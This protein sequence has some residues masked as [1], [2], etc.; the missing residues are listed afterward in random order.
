MKT[1]KGK[2]VVAS[3]SHRSTIRPVLETRAE[4]LLILTAGQD[5]PFPHSQTSDPKISNPNANQ[6]QGRMANRSGHFADLPVFA[7]DQFERDP[8]FGDA[9]SK[10]N[11]WL[12]R[13]NHCRTHRQIWT[14]MV[15]G[16]DGLRLQHPRLARQRSAALDQN[17]T[18]QVLH[19][20]RRWNSLDLRPIFPLVGANGMEKFLIQVRLITQKE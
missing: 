9:L 11:G 1:E 19:F 14:A 20:L 6:T 7:F 17:A 12:A 13:R 5:F 2:R 15:I 8:T 4:H 16:R 18:S 3:L 10:S